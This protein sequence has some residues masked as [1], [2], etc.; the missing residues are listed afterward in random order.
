MTKPT[1][2]LVPE[3][4]DATLVLV[5][6][7]ESTFIVEGRFQGQAETPLSEMGLRQADLVAARLATPHSMPALPVPGGPPLEMIHSPLLRTTQT[8]DA[9]SR[10]MHAVGWTPPVRADRGFAEI[11]Q[12]VWQGLLHTEVSERYGAELAAWRR[13]PLEG[14]APG[15]ESLPDVQARVRESLAAVVAR[16][17]A[18]RPAGTLDRPQVPG[19]GDAPATHPWSIVVGHDGIFK[20]ALLTLF[21]LPLDRFW[22]WSMDLCGITIVEIRAGRPTLRAHNLTAHLAMVGPDPAIDPGGEKRARSG[23]L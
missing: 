12:D 23:A 20:V 7:G 10:A 8:A 21:D 15:G 13:T 22:M 2:T 14:F 9:I 19:Y 6:H 16:L 3:G 4:L 11:H 5:R 1:E 18:G 17:A